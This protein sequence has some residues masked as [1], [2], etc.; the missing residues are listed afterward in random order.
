MKKY[1]LFFWAVF[2]ISAFGFGQN[3]SQGEIRNIKN[4]H[5]KHMVFL[6]SEQHPVMVESKLHYVTTNR[7]PLN[8]TRTTAKISPTVYEGLGAKA[9]KALL[10]GAKSLKKGRYAVVGVMAIGTYNWVSGKK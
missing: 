8:L 10:N 4:T 5:P 3:P 6:D 9:G 2:A 1:I 7:F